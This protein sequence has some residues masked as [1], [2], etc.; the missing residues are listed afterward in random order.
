MDDNGLA[1]DVINRG[2]AVAL[3]LEGE[4]DLDCT[5]E[6]QTCLGPVD[7]SVPIVALDLGGVTFVDS[8]GLVTI[9]REH[10][11]LSEAGRTLELHRV[12]SRVLDL[13]A[14][15]ELLDYLQVVI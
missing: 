15:T 9:V 3:L 14:R 2:G 7:A 8:W 13:L 10:R 4:L 12:P 6:L 1:I 5:D 11:R